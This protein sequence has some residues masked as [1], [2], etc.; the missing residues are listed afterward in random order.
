MAI[1]KALRVLIKQ[2][3]KEADKALAASD[4]PEIMRGNGQ[5]GPDRS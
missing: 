1:M 2:V 5:D 3:S 4:G